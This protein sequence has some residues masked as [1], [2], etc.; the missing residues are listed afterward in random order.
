MRDRKRQRSFECLEIRCLLA[1]D[2]IGLKINEIVAVNQS[3]LETRVREEADDRYRGAMLTPDWI[4]LYNDSDV[5]L[6]LSGAAFTDD[7]K[8]FDRWH[9]PPETTIASGRHL[10]VFASGLDVKNAEL[11]E[12]GILH[13]DLKF[14]ARGEYIAVLDSDGE[15]VD[16]VDTYPRLVSDLA[17]GRDA[18]GFTLLASPTPGATNSVRFEGQVA[19]TEVNVNRGFYSQPFTVSVSTATEGA[20]IR[21]T[22][23]G[24]EPTRTH[25]TLYSAPIAISTTT[26]LRTAA[27]KE[28]FVPTDVDTQT[29]MFVSDVVNQ[30]AEIEGF[31]S[32]GRVWAGG[33]T[34]VPQDTEMDPEIV[35]DPAYAEIIDDSLLAIPTLSIT[36]DQGRIF[37]N[38]GWYDGEDVEAAV[39]VELLYPDDASSNQ[40]INAGI[41]SHSHD[42]LKRSLRLNF[43]EEY[44]DSVFKTDFFQRSP[45]TGDSAT[46]QFNAIIL[47]GGNNRSW[48]HDWNP[49]KTAYA[50]D[51]FYRSSQVAMSGYGMRGQVTHLYIN[52]VYWGLYNPVERADQ[53]FG[54]EYFGGAAEDWFTMNHGGDLAGNDDRWDRLRRLGR[55]DMTVQ[56]NYEELKEHLDLDAFIDYL[57]IAWWT[58]VSDWPQNNYYGTNR[59]ESSNLDPNPFRFVAWDGE[60]S[61]GQGGQSSSDGRAHVHASFRANS[62]AGEPIPLLWRG[63]GESR[64]H[65]AISRSRLPASVW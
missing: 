10:V 20:E 29:Y 14:N 25:G 58:A 18:T 8:H 53:D 33:N 37:G 64:V 35:G 54:S 21:Y 59:N 1:G 5:A 26:N 17:F 16:L 2:L 56:E 32:G 41:E 28:G 13:A 55:E 4:E 46:D 3:T 15:V 11:D 23:D 27:F 24:S 61:W 49:D 22:T 12:S 40:Q 7:P 62:R 6:D 44:G 9:F 36:S 65:V 30:P 45:V 50:I 34:Y 31:P 39:S 63:S 51:E 52:G 38:T 48:A 60:W 47:R 19:G 57:I 42:R 43:R